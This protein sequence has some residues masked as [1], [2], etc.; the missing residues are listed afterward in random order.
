RHDPRA[1]LDGPGARG[2]GP[3]GV[4]P[5][6]PTDRRLS[7]GPRLPRRRRRGPSGRPRT[8]SPHRAAVRGRRAPA[9]PGAVLS[10]R[11]PSGGGT[12]EIASSHDRPGGGTRWGARSFGSDGASAEE[13]EKNHPELVKGETY[14]FQVQGFRFPI[15]SKPSI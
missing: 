12:A 14:V 6:G 1:R 7:H 5:R 8:A 11:S 10:P 9:A 13:L 15:A 3:G 4:L 2:A